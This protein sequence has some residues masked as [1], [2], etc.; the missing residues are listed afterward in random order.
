M[1]RRRNEDELVVGPDERD[2]P[3]LHDPIFEAYTS[4]EYLVICAIDEPTQALA[5]KYPVE[6][7]Q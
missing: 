2:G 3:A 7:E 6:I 1:I 4:G 5:A